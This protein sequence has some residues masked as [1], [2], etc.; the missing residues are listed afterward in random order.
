[1]VSLKLRQAPF[2]TLAL[3]LALSLLGLFKLEIVHTIPSTKPVVVAGTNILDN[4]SGV[5]FN[6]FNN[7]LDTATQTLNEPTLKLASDI[8]CKLE[9]ATSNSSCLPH[10]PDASRTVPEIIRA[11][12]FQVEELEAVTADGYILMV[13]RIINPLVPREQRSS[14]K[15]V[16]LQHGLMTCSVDWVINSMEVKPRRPTARSDRPLAAVLPAWARA[17]VAATGG[18]IRPANGTTTRRDNQRSSNGLGLF[19]ANEGY[20]VY[21]ANSRGNA[22]SKRH[23]TLSPWSPA[24]WDFTFDQLIKFD[25]PATIE[26]VQR[27]SGRKKLA[28]VGHSQ[29]TAIMFGLLAD[30]PEFADL[31]EPIIMLAPVAFV[32]NVN[33]PARHFA[34]YTP[35]FQHVNMRFGTSS[36][37]IRYLAPIVCGVHQVV[38]KELCQNVI[39]LTSGFNED[40]FDA[41][42]LLGY[43]GHLP[44]GTSVKNLAHYGQEINSG[45][46]AHFDHGPT[47][48]RQLYG[49]TQAPDYQLKRVRSRSI[50]LF[51]ADTD[52]LSTPPDLAKLRANL[53]VKPYKTFNLTQ[54]KPKWSHMDFMYGKS[55]GRLVNSRILDVLREFDDDDDDN[56]HDR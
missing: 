18:S 28:Y 1:M 50:I 11:R 45:R 12:G 38:R 24:F 29:G 55:S 48:N 17:R 56:D 19:L 36:A 23:V 33:T 7:V 13:H 5:L 21:L 26:L 31:V 43:L 47:V 46:F 40:E 52:W 30:R 41:N 49:Q 54:I 37:V 3:A 8:E 44:S 53:G 10:D 42:R 32:G 6:T 22:Y 34:S 15:P 27:K 39:F 25:L 4:L 9:Q 2:L 16:L 20:D 14:L 51:T 35:I